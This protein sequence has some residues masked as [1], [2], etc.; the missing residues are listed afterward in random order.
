MRRIIAA[1]ILAWAFVGIAAVCGDE[2]WSRFRGPNGSG[3]AE[4]VELP[5]QWTDDDY[6]WRVALPGKGHS[7][8]I[9]WGS[10]IFVTAADNDAGQVI[11]AAFDAATGDEL[12]TRRF[13]SPAYKMHQS[14]SLASSTPAADGERVYVA[15]VC[16]GQLNLAAVDHDGGEVWRRKLGPVDF[17]HGYGAS[18]IV[19]DDLVI[20]SCDCE[21]DSFVAAL[22]AP[23][24]EERWRRRRA[25]G[26]DSYA[27][28][29]VWQATDGKQIVVASTAEGL[30][31]LAPGDG[32]PLWSLPDVFAARCVGSPVVADGL[33]IAT[34]GE[35]G[36]GRSFAAVKPPTGA[37]EPT[38]VYELDRSL[39]QAPTPVVRGK[40]LFVVSDR[41]VATCCDLSTGK[42]HWTARIG[43]NYFASPVIGG[44]KLYCVAADGAVVVLAAD[45][46]YNLLGRHELG[47]PCE[48]TPAI[49]AGRLYLRTEGSL[50]CLAGK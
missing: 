11:L 23:T 30:V 18:P 39:P 45:D 33:V 42:Q 16:Q 31:A 28:P 32:E 37:E 38:V 50:A 14:N 43:G 24:G 27:T 44:D 21:G 3:V 19:V 1:A 26:I 47:E 46:E 15:W 12:W 2:N 36:N 49:H 35:G 4:G 20:V 25:S 7:S 40:L 8:P 9:G 22:D 29:A 34:S 10:R 48:A 17:R 13:E 41:G 6:A 5:A